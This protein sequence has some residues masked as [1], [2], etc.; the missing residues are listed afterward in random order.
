MELWA[1]RLLVFVAATHLL[2]AIIGIVPHM[3]SLAPDGLLGAVDPPWNPQHP[4]R[5]AAFWISL[6]SFAGPQLLWGLWVIRSASTGQRLPGSTGLALLILTVVQVSLAPV[7]GFWLNL[8]P[9]VLLI[10]AEVSGR[11]PARA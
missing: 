7:G 2:L 4:D 10:A 6:G 9:A 11:M 5:Q 1:G 3:G 8:L